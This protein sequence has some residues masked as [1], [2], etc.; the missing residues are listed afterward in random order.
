MAKRIL[1]EDVNSAM[2]Y[3]HS[4]K[5]DT[6]HYEI[7][8][9]G[10]NALG[11]QLLNED[12]LDKALDV[13]KLNIEEHPS[14]ANPFDSYGDA[15]LMKGDSVNALKNFKKCFEMDSTL[16]NAKDKFEKLEAALKQ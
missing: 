13:F 5:L 6:L 3:Y 15:L 8:E 16:S 10:L 9:G 4:K 14:S 1:T 12:H 11:Y 2:S 7:T